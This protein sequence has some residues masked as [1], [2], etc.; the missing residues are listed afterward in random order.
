MLFIIYLLIIYQVN[1][2]EFRILRDHE[3]K[4]K[5]YEHWEKIKDLPM[6]EKLKDSTS[7]KQA[8]LRREH[9][10]EE[11]LEE[12]DQEKLRFDPRKD[13]AHFYQKVNEATKAKVMYERRENA[14]KARGNYGTIL[15]TFQFH[16]LN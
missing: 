3:S 15:K 6:S 2:Q 13:V 4:V 1:S 16:L 7:R 8:Y 10:R 9:Q 14:R 5:K 11:R 12:W